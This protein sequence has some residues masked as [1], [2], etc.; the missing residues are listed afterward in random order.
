MTPGRRSAGMRR[1]SRCWA[2]KL[3]LATLVLV[4]ANGPAYAHGP[5]FSPGPETIWK[6]GTELT[7]GFH[8]AAATG[9]GDKAKR[10]EVFLEAEYGLTAN[11]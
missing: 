7:L 9:A 6:G 11:W 5:L 4:F 3:P 8:A 2:A 1:R 10:Y